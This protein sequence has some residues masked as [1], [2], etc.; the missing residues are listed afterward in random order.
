MS[1][2]VKLKFKVG[3]DP[4]FTLALR[5][6]R[7]NADL[8]NELCKYTLRNKGGE[9]GMDVGMAEM[10]PKPAYDI[11]ELAKNIKAIIKEASKTI[12]FM[13]WDTSSN[14]AAVGGHIHFE[15]PEEY[16]KGD[17]GEWE[18]RN[19]KVHDYARKMFSFYL[20]VWMADDY[21]K[22]NKT[23]AASGS[24]GS[25]GYG[26]YGDYRV[27]PH[28]GK[29]T[30]EL[31][32]PSAQWLTSPKTMLATFMY[33]AAVHNEIIYHPETFKEFTDILVKNQDEYIV[34]ENAARQGTPMFINPLMNKLKRA[35]KKFELYPSFKREINWLFNSDNVKEEKEKASWDVLKGWEMEPKELSLASLNNKRSVTARM[36][37]FN[38]REFNNNWSSLIPFTFNDDFNVSEWTQELSKRIFAMNWKIKRSY[39]FYGFRKDGI[40]EAVIADRNFN[41]YLGGSALKT[42]EEQG[43]AKRAIRKMIEKYAP[44][45]NQYIVG[46]PYEVRQK[47]ELKFLIQL[48]HFMEHELPL[49]PQDLSKEEVAKL[50]CIQNAK[51]AE[52]KKKLQKQTSKT[53]PFEIGATVRLKSG[54]KEKYT[55]NQPFEG[56]ATY[57][58]EATNTPSNQEQFIALKRHDKIRGSA[59]NGY[60]LFAKEDI[61]HLELALSTVPQEYR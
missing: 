28:G 17:S 8:A 37:R 14:I 36:E 61:K 54:W 55:I 46:L 3:C 12:G 4:E 6:K 42:E 50:M 44:T 1:Q 2:K 34:I 22:T 41:I 38:H 15:L 7:I 29:Y 47:N 23:R 21:K 35:I 31:R 51:E 45:P 58:G 24:I 32:T 10:R 60:W 13:Q 16:T 39:L 59:Q 25:G 49:M 20:P 26:H 56:L 52:P 19:A 57:M 43:Q 48:T 11:I 27:D 18:I 5:N 53:Y 9:L 33:L 30:F 40:S